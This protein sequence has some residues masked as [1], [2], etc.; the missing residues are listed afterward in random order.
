MPNETLPIRA[1]IRARLNELGWT[2]DYFLR[3]LGY[4]KMPKARQHLE[5]LYLGDCTRRMLVQRL[6]EALE[7]P[8]AFVRK[9]IEDT[10]RRIAEAED[11]AYRAVFKPHAV[12]LTERLIPQPISAAAF[13]GQHGSNASTL[14]S[15][16]RLQHSSGRRWTASTK[17][18]SSSIQ[19]YR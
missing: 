12:I 17:S 7:V 9:A 3:R 5:Q 8:P 2:E 16:C 14:R 11:A 15:P 18:C 10:G 4:R 1:F 19:V 13:I 6:P